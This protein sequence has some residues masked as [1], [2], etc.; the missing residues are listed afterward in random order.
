MSGGTARV[1]EVL[2]P[3]PHTAPPHVVQRLVGMLE[4]LVEQRQPWLTVHEPVFH[5]TTRL[6]C[7]LADAANAQPEELVGPVGSPLRAHVMRRVVDALSAQ[8]EDWLAGTIG[9]SEQDGLALVDSVVLVPQDTDH[10][11][12]R[13]TS[14]L[15][16]QHVAVEVDGRPWQ[17]PVVAVQ[18]AL[19]AGSCRVIIKGLYHDFA[20]KGV[21]ESLLRGVGYAPDEFVVLAQRA[22]RI[23][24]GDGSYCR[25]GDLRTVVGVVRCL[26]PGDR[27]LR[28]LP[29]ELRGMGWTA[30]VTV[31][32]G[33]P[34]DASSRS[35]F[36]RRP[37]P[38]AP[39]SCPPRLDRVLAGNGLTP[40]AM[41]AGPVP[42]A[43]AA[44]RASR[45]P[46]D[47]AGLGSEGASPGQASTVFVRAA[48]HAPMQVEGPAAPGLAPPLVPVP[49]PGSAQVRAPA[50]A[51]GP[52]PPSQLARAPL[53]ESAHALL[54]AGRGREVEMLDPQP[55]VPDAPGAS[56]ALGWLMD[57]SD[58]PRPVA[59]L[60]LRLAIESHPGLWEENVQASTATSLTASFRR[61]LHSHVSAHLGACTAGPLEVADAQGDVASVRSGG[62]ARAGARP[63]AGGAAPAP[64]PALPDGPHTRSRSVP[65]RPSPCP[66]PDSAAA[67][68][69]S[70][71]HSQTNQQWFV[72]NSPSSRAPGHGRGGRQ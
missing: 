8:H 31:V 63:E 32:P 25:L 24:M 14:A 27:C 23:S 64:A 57:E 35:T 70:R 11:M 42:V 13:L 15:A 17:L 5:S 29:A 50:L 33:V 60:L 66:P 43:E 16:D 45:Q 4:E 2:R 37:P 55:D 18:A 34:D 68:V 51:P 69:R 65:P 38:R 44:V 19:P 9:G 52:A 58:V 21:L 40:E 30:R 22:G 54:A 41:A 47:T 3:R 39:R 1:I 36:H 20:R 49:A 71:Q 59:V 53:G 48:G 28:R 61:V 62:V 46:R 26:A 12:G 72:V 56:A 67:A 6:R 7:Q 10:G